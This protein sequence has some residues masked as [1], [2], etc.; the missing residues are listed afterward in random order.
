MFHGKWAVLFP[1]Y[2]FCI[3][4][5]EYWIK[6]SFQFS[7]VAALPW[8]NFLR[9]NGMHKSANEVAV[10][11]CN[12][13]IVDVNQEPQGLEFDASNTEPEGDMVS[14]SEDHKSLCRSGNL[15]W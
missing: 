4:I 11:I 13:L 7:I 14:H 6:I 2:N 5:S 15:T 9:N 12:G 10:H 3:G 8:H 1:P